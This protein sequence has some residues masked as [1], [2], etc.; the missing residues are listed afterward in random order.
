MTYLKSIYV[1]NCYVSQHFEIDFSPFNTTAF[2]HLILTGKNGSGKTTILK[3]LNQTL[4]KAQTDGIRFCLPQLESQNE[5]EPNVAMTLTNQPETKLELKNFLEGGLYG[6]LK[7]ERDTPVLTVNG[8][9]KLEVIDLTGKEQLSPL[10][11]QFLVNKKTEQAYAYQDGDQASVQQIEQWFNRFEQQ[12][13]FLFDSSEL[14][15]EFNRKEFNFYI[16]LPEQQRFDFNQLS[17]GYASVLSIITEILMLRE[18]Q[19]Q[20]AQLKVHL[21]GILLIDEIENHLHLALQEKIL[22][23]LTTTFP[24]IQFIVAT[25]SPAVIASIDNATVYDL[26]T[27]RTVNENLMGMPYHVLMKSHFGIE[28]EYSLLATEKLKKVKV[29]LQKAERTEQ[30]NETLQQLARELDQLSPDLSLEIFLELEHK[31]HQ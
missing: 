24:Q 3:A 6:Y 10:F 4:R 17:H 22:P 19:N 8:P 20:K 28:S 18:S 30:D 12:L 2:R 13:Q 1:N 21:P 5:F 29:L 14:R 16:K 23:F 25:H 11:V 31:K 7:V 27:H 15:L 26:D 9:Q